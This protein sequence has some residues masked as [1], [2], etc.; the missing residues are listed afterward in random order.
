MNLANTNIVILLLVCVILHSCSS[1]K[2]LAKD[3]R[4]ILKQ[5]FVINDELLNKEPVTV[6]SQTPENTRLFGI[7][8]KLHLY[9]LSKPN[10]AKRFDRWLT[11]NPNEKNN[12]TNGCRQNNLIN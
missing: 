5:S 9:N 10:P 3:D 1:T 11:K 7:P 6:L 2:K 8:F 4:L 12:S